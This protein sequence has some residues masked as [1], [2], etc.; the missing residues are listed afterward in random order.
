MDLLE[1]LSVKNK[2]K[3]IEKLVEQKKERYVF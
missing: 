1:K 3:I 2:E